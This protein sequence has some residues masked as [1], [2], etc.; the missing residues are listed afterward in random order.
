MSKIQKF[1]FEL[2]IFPQRLYVYIG[3]DMELIEKAIVRDSGETQKA[4]HKQVRGGYAGLTFTYKGGF[5]GIIFREGF[6]LNL[7]IVAHESFHAVEYLY[8][9]VGIPYC[10]H[11]SESY[12]YMLEF[13]V[14][15]ITDKVIAIENKNT[16]VPVPTENFEGGSQSKV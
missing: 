9:R 13:I 11:T 7:G 16:S 2:G 10:E 14:N 3:D 4:V 1:N 15:K 6:Q 8:Q 5:I 12:A